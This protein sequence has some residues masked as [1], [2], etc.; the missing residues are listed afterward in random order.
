MSDDKNQGVSVHDVEEIAKALADI[1]V[2]LGDLSKDHEEITTHRVFKNAQSMISD[3]IKVWLGA[4]IFILVFTGF[5]SYQGVVDKATDI[6]TT[7][8]LPDIKKEVKQKVNAHIN[9]TVDR[10][11]ADIYEVVQI[12]TQQQLEQFAGQLSQELNQP[13][14]AKIETKTAPIKEQA[15]WVYLGS[16]DGER[17]DTRYLDFALKDEPESLIGTAQNVR[18][19]TGAL[20]VRSDMPNVFGQFAKVIDVL[21]EGTNVR[22]KEVDEWSSSGY[23]WAYVSYGGRQQKKWA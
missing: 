7:T 17:W 21:G 23:W 22:I 19:K 15:G 12:K 6:F 14:I 20:N 4:G 16:F 1:R 10:A 11:T 13:E 9:E 3:W 18:K 8:I 2:R 5:L